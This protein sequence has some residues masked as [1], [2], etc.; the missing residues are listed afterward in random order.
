[1]KRSVV[2]WVEGNITTG[3]VIDIRK[4][5]NECQIRLDGRVLI[6]PEGCHVDNHEHAERIYGFKIRYDYQL[7]P[8]TFK[9]L[10]LTEF[11]FEE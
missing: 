10:Y 7:E 9:V 3:S 2:K 11:K 8:N 6:L 5:L 4:E 1:M